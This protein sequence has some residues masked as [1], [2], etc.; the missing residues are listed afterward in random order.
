MVKA[1]LDLGTKTTCA[2]KDNS[3]GSNKYL[4]KIRGPPLSQTL[5]N[6]TM[7]QFIDQK[8]DREINWQ[9]YENNR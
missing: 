9:I 5:E 3:L 1:W 2:R 8:I 6:I 4:V 7:I